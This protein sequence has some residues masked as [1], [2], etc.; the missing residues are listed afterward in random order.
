MQFSLFLEQSA[1]D[2]ETTMYQYV[3]LTVFHIQNKYH[4][5]WKT[6]NTTFQ[7]IAGLQLWGKGHEMEKKLWDK[8]VA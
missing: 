1:Q 7:C 5:V 6:V 4:H 3:V 8:S 2:W